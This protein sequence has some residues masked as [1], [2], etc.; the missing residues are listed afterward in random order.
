VFEKGIQK[1]S[2]HYFYKV[3]KFNTNSEDIY[4]YIYTHIYIHLFNAHVYE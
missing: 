2:I 1:T 4:T 3:E